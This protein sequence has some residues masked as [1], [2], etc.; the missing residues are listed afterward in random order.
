MF[1]LF[2]VLELPACAK[3]VP[4]VDQEAPLGHG[5]DIQKLIPF[6]Q[7]NQLRELVTPSS[8]RVESDY[9]R[10]DGA[11]ALFPAYAAFAQAVYVGLDETSVR[12]FTGPEG[13][14]LLQRAGYVPLR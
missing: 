1:M 13:Q 4:M 9:P 10:L 3:P 6:S 12:R 14:Y 8:F 2:A 7:N 11:I 5:V